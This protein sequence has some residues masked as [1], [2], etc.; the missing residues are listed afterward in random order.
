[1]AWLGLLETEPLPTVV[2]VRVYWFWVKVAVTALLLV[3]LTVVERLVP[4][5]SPL[6]LEKLHPVLGIAVKV[7][8]VP[9]V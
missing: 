5:A 8:I 9:Q 2:I 3:M 1:V 4:E 7:T 6:Q